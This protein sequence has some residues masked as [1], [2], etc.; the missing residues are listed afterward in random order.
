MSDIVAKKLQE[1]AD[2]RRKIIA[3]E[4]DRALNIIL[5]QKQPE[6]LVQSFNPEDLHILIKEIGVE[7][8]L[9]I[10]QMASDTQW[11]YI[12]DTEGWNKDRLDTKAVSVWLRYLYL[13]DPERFIKQALADNLEL[14]EA[15][16]QHNIDVVIREHDEDLSHLSA[17]FFTL[18]DTFYVRV[19]SNPDDFNPDSMDDMDRAQ[20][21]R[22]FLN[23]LADEDY[24]KYQGILLETTAT[25]NAETEEELYRIKTGRLEEKGI[26]SFENALEIYTMLPFEHLAK[27]KNVDSDYRLNPPILPGA[28]AANEAKPI[29]DLSPA[30]MVLPPDFDQEFATLANSIL[31]A[32]QTKINERK[33]MQKA[34]VK[35]LGYLHIAAQV[36]ER[37]HKISAMQA[38]NTYSTDQ[39]F[40][41]GFSQALKL[42]WQAQNWLKQSFIAKNKLGVKFFDEEGMGILSGLFLKRPMYFDNLKQGSFY[43]EFAAYH[44]IETTAAALNQIIAVDNLLNA[45]GLL[46]NE[47]AAEVEHYPL[48]WKNLLLTMW[49]RHELG[50]ENNQ[51][52]IATAALQDFWPQLFA[53]GGL[54]TEAKAK[55]ENWLQ[56]LADGK[57]LDKNMRQAVGSLFNELNESYAK[58][59]HQYLDAKHITLFRLING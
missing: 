7:D 29:P 56:E 49:V 21:I 28:L 13:S 26:P 5:D 23:R 57:P 4:P 24:A 47:N 3:D 55:F 8:A 53:N 41:F 22:E 11:T 50:Y 38:I 35:A 14:V 32:D 58:I 42:K 48:T 43:R 45:T 25:L 17:D 33:D 34:V 12:L 40:S 52:P 46:I 16:L 51:E 18:D 6:I 39:L 19:K 2:L 1:L 59:D 37:D 36:L 54:N 31:V 20:F 15:W 10:V 27:R 44:D 9:P 30:T